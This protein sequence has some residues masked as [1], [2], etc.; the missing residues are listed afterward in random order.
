MFVC[1]TGGGFFWFFVLLSIVTWFGLGVVAEC[2]VGW[3]C[4]FVVTFCRLYWLLCFVVFGVLWCIS[5]VAGFTG[6]VVWVC[7]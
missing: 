1:S 7:I 3:F 4:V 6:L 2:F 5:L